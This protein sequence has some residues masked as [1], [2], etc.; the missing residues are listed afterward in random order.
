[1][2]ASAQDRYDNEQKEKEA[3]K[4]SDD[5]PDTSHD[6]QP[7]LFSRFSNDPKCFKI[8]SQFKKSGSIQENSTRKEGYVIGIDPKGSDVALVTF[9]PDQIPH[10]FII[11]VM[12]P[13]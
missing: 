1:M 6:H 4:D 2:Y 11:L 13:P 3:N 5:A 9:T 12:C 7:F 8:T 10:D